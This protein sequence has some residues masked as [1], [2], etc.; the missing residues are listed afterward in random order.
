LSEFQLSLKNL[1]QITFLHFQF[2]LGVEKCKTSSVSSFGCEKIKNQIFWKWMLGQTRLNSL[3]EDWIDFSF[4]LESKR[5]NFCSKQKKKIHHQIWVISESKDGDGLN[6]FWSLFFF[7]TFYEVFFMQK[8]N[9]L[10]N[11]RLPWNWKWKGAGGKK[12]EKEG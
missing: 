2:W 8:M 3:K 1:S 7:F 5:S 6:V 11:Q 4:F 9:R 10:S 12:R